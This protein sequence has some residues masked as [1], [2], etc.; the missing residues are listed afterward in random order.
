MIHNAIYGSL[1]RFIGILLE[2]TNGRL[3]TWLA[4]IQIQVLNLTDRNVDYA[5]KIIRKI[6]E[7]IPNARIDAD[8]RQVPLP[9]K[10]KE[11]EIMRVPYIV[12]VG[13]KEEK[14]KTLALRVR[15][16]SKI[17]TIKIDS[18]IEKVKKEIAERV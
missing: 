14:E 18:F 5:Q 11:A 9:G 1:E 10:I 6:G 12:V 4:P 13:D 3:P 8:F 2:H 15:G 7:E 16:N 17:E